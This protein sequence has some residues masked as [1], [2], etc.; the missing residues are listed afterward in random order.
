MHDVYDADDD[1]DDDDDDDRTASRR[2]GEDAR[3]GAKPST[4]TTAHAAAARASTTRVFGVMV[5]WCGWWKWM[6]MSYV[7]YLSLARYG[8]LKRKIGRYLSTPGT[9]LL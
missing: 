2:D 5:M 7:P 8:L 9:Y 4:S 6:R 3:G 1:D